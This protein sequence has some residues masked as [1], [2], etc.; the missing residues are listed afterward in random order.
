M[1]DARGFQVKTKEDKIKE[2]ISSINLEEM[3]KDLEEEAREL[4]ISAL[5]EAT[6][7]FGAEGIRITR[8]VFESGKLPDWASP[9]L[10][11]DWMAFM[12]NAHADALEKQRKA[13]EKMSE[14]AMKIG[15]EVLK[16]LIVSF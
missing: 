12:Q 1:P 16:I 4:F 6:D 3:F 14:I 7:R 13:T 5:K 15:L 8:E 11:S 10:E 2:L 9:R